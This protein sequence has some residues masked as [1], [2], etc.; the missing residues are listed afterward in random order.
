MVYSQVDFYSENPQDYY[1]GVI[2]SKK[3]RI[4]ISGSLSTVEVRRE[5][6]R[7]YYQLNKEKCKE[8][9][10]EYNLIHK[11]KKRVD[12]VSTT[13]KGNA[14]RE[15]IRTTFNASELQSAPVEKTIRMLE[16]II[17]GERLFTM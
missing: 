5:Y 7:L 3:T 17:N 15:V 9:Q 1:N 14:K 10:R 11:K 13:K 2:K 16:K 4:K 12:R 6:Q 8:Y